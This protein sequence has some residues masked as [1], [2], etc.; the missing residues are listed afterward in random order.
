MVSEFTQNVHYI[1]QEIWIGG[2]ASTYMRGFAHQQGDLDLY[3][4]YI[5]IKK[6]SV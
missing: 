5:Y 3:R 2:H 1:A 4:H 6:I